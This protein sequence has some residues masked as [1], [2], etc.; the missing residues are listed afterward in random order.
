MDVDNRYLS[1]VMV[2]SCEPDDVPEIS[3]DRVSYLTTEDVRFRAGPGADCDLTTI[4]GVNQEA[5]LLGGPVM[6]EDDSFV[7]AQVE[8]AGQTGWVVIDVLEPVG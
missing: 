7:W 5:T 2:T 4:I 6:R 8:I 3:I 1:T